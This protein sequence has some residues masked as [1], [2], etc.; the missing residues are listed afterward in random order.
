[1]KSFLTFRRS[2]S[3]HAFLVCHISYL[4]FLI[5]TFFILATKGFNL[6]NKGAHRHSL[7][8]LQKFQLPVGLSHLCG[9][10]QESA[11]PL[12]PYSDHGKFQNS[13]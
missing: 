10:L 2:N 3:S 4:F 7:M 9:L 8:G 6:M 1:M 12:L 11:L 5:I 13:K